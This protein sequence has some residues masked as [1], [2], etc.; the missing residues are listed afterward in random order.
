M[1]ISFLLQMFG[2]FV[3][4]V[5]VFRILACPGVRAGALDGVGC[6]TIPP[7][8]IWSGLSTIVVWL[9]SLFAWPCVSVFGR[10][11]LYGSVVS[12][13]TSYDGRLCAYGLLMIVILNMTDEFTLCGFG[14]RHKVAA[15]VSNPSVFT[16]HGRG[17]PPFPNIRTS[18]PPEYFN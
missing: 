2:S 7:A 13:Y 4:W 14:C 6:M 15:T 16:P 11:C 1:E 17:F 8:W 12:Y 3:Y 10:T 5:N 18:L 9:R